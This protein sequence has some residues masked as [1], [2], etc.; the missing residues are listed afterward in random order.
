[1][2]IDISCTR[3]RSTLLGGELTVE[4]NDK[5]DGCGGGRED[6]LHLRVEY[7]STN[8]PF[9]KQRL[10]VQPTRTYW[11]RRLF[12]KDSNQH[13]SDLEFPLSALINQIIS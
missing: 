1:M 5:Q 6:A 8:Y 3:P 10:D 9:I 4:S 13:M 7:T 2:P 12:Q 11:A